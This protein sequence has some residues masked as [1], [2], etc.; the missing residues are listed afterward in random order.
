MQSIFREIKTLD[1]E[2]RKQEFSFGF[3]LEDANKSK[4]KKKKKRAKKGN[5]S[6][7]AGQGADSGSESD[8]DMND[9]IKIVSD[10]VT[11]A[12]K[13]A[14]SIH[15]NV[16]APPGLSGTISTKAPT[17]P[18]AAA[19]NKDDAA[20]DDEE[21][22]DNNKATG[23]P[24]KKK[25]KKNKKK[26]ASETD[27]KVGQSKKVLDD[28]DDFL[29]AAIA[30]A[31]ADRIVLEKANKAAE[32]ERAKSRKLDKTKPPKGPVFL[33]AKDPGLDESNKA[34]AKFGN[35]KNLVKVGPAKVR[36]ANWLQASELPQTTAAAST[37]AQSVASLK[38]AAVGVAVAAGGP[39]EAA[40]NLPAD[41]KYHN[42]PFTFGFGFDL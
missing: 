32:K 34:K 4:K 22:D 36:D 20:S 5:K 8:G 35:G 2:E 21:D 14:K 13:D 37:V 41:T 15:Q 1:E 9:L 3:D 39:K 18:I 24:K 23:D 38:N 19:S 10:T 40:T 33:S 26:K 25:K 17:Q 30:K 42:S 12:D 31:E 28:D 11:L 7:T 16:N 27:G 6:S 29:N